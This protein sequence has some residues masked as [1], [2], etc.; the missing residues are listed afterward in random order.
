MGKARK[1]TKKIKTK[2]CLGNIEMNFAILG[3]SHCGKTSLVKRFLCKSFSDKYNPT[4]MDVFEEHYRLD[5]TDVGV[6]YRIFD[7]TGSD[8]F[9]AMRQLAINSADTFVIVYAV[10]DRKSFEDAKKVKMEILKTKGRTA[11]I[12][13]LLVASKCDVDKENHVVSSEEGKVLA[14]HWGCHFAETSAKV[15]QN[16]D[17]LFTQPMIKTLKQKYPELATRFQ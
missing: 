12:P 1:S 4:S 11:D 9:P 8:D 7:I 16:I 10:N 17:N 15:S 5:A 13:I 6:S 2:S 14:K 3:S